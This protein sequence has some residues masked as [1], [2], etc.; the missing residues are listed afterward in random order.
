MSPRFLH[1]SRKLTAAVIGV[2]LNAAY[3]EKQHV[4]LKTQ[5]LHFTEL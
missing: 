1:Q 3:L 5:Q 4:V 2:L